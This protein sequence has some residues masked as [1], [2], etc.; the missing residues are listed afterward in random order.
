VSGLT[1][2]AI[3][4]LIDLWHDSDDPRPLHAFLGM[5]WDE[6]KRW[7]SSP[8]DDFEQGGTGAILD[9]SVAGAAKEDDNP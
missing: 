9:G 2:E 3:D 1:P 6:Y 5:T 7:V 8:H 4:D